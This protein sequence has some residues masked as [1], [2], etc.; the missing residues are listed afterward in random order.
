MGL[1]FYLNSI[2]I[3]FIILQSDIVQT[4][5]HLKWLK[6][7]QKDNHIKQIPTSFPIPV[8]VQKTVLTPGP[9]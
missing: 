8:S 5:H 1:F 2:K 9:S 7:L 6:C 4:F 3:C